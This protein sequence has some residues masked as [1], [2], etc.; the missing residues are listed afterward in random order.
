MPALI[1]TDYSA[2]VV[3]LGVVPYRARAEID[4]R[5]VDEMPLDFGGMAG[6]HHA[7]RIRPSCSRV[8]AQHPRDTEI[9]NVRQLSVV[10]LEEM[11]Q[12]ACKIGL[13]ELKPEWL[14]ASVVLTGLPDFSHLPPSSRLQGPD[15]VTLVVDMQNRPCNLPTKTIVEEVGDPGRG[16]KAAAEGLRG[17]TAWVERPGTLSRGD[18]LRL[19]IPDQRG[20]SGAR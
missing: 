17:V 2:T 16:F 11:D 15:G 19:H 12:I 9:A 13:P 7:G 4:G 3:W 6:E 10:S 20:W 14:G 1:P 18:R 5:A 8:I